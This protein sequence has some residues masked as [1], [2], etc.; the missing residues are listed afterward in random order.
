MDNNFK[1]M[2]ENNIDDKVFLVLDALVKPLKEANK[3]LTDQMYKVLDIK[4]KADDSAD[5]SQDMKDLLSD[6]VS[7]LVKLQFALNSQIISLRESLK[8]IN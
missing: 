8:S 6:N 7:K 2:D 4:V 1:Q 5:I 3:I